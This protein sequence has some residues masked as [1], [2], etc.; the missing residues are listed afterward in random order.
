[1]AKY[2]TSVFNAAYAGAGFHSGN[3]WTDS[4]VAFSRA[5]LEANQHYLSGVLVPMPCPTEYNFFFTHD[6]LLTNLS[7]IA[8][9]PNR[10]RR[11]LLY[12]AGHAKGGV[13]PHAYYWKDD[14]FKT[15]YCSPGNWN[16]IWFILATA[17]YLRH[18]MDTATVLRLY[19]LLA[20]SLEQTMS[21]RSGNVMHGTEPDWWDFGHAI[22]ARAYL[23]ILTIRA[24]DEFVFVSAWLRKDLSRL[25]AYEATAAALRDGL[26]KELWDD[27]SGYLMNSIGSEPDPHI[28][29]GPLLAAVYGELPAAHA[30]RLVSTARNRLVD[31]SIGIRTVFPADFHTD[32]VKNLYKVK[33]NEAGDAFMYANGGV[34]YLGNAWYARALMSIG[35]VEGAFD[36]YART[37][38]VD[39]IVQSPSGQPALYEYR[40]AN[41]DAPNHGW[42][43]KPTM[44]WSAGFCIGTAYLL[45]GIEDNVWNVTA[46]GNAAEAL[47]HVRCEYAFGGHKTLVRHGR[48]PMLIRLLAD[49]REIPSRILPLDA[50]RASSITV[51]MGAIRYPFLDSVNAIL[52]TASLD[53]DARTFRCTLS[54]FRDHQTAVKLITPWLA[55][56]VAINGKAWKDWAVTSTPT[57]TLMVTV[58]YGASEGIDTVEIWF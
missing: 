23:T 3:A 45:S 21:R 26:V 20:K 42:I 49:K 46:A 13:I 35:D 38:T 32:S 30:K 5:L 52:H 56:S 15:E 14:G 40:Y 4:S 10:V 19:P 43:D 2:R 33:G 22:G 8:F 9:D 11:D 7:A 47:E 39:G 53:P 12:L 17:S 29:M 50:G 31:S 1:M 41:P 18:S 28:Y 37:M 36:F 48:G 44:M 25:A 55:R 54:S 57:G 58:R 24:L 51:D 27:S 34:W 6:A 16:N